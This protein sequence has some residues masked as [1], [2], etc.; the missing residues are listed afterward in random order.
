[1]E[2]ISTGLDGRPWPEFLFDRRPVLVVPAAPGRLPAP[3]DGWADRDTALAL[4]AGPRPSWS[5]VLDESRL[6]I[7]RPGGEA[8]FDGEIGVTR[9][10]RRAVRAHRTLLLVTGPFANPFEFTAAV[11]AG[12]LLLL[13]TP[14]RLDSGI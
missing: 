10:W 12:R 2:M 8:W 14:I 4:T 7:H 3:E 6:V 5:A 9:E 11:G 1:M 13:T